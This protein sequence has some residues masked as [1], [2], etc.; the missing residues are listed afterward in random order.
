LTGEK[1]ETIVSHAAIAVAGSLQ[2]VPL[3]AAAKQFKVNV[4]T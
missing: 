4:M 3:E 1:G 2:G